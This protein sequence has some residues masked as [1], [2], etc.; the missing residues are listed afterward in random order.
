MTSIP[1]EQMVSDN[2]A[3]NYDTK[4]GWRE[5]KFRGRGEVAQKIDTDKVKKKKKERDKDNQEVKRNK[6][7]SEDRYRQNETTE[8]RGR[9]G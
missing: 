8:K 6:G 2:K 3:G 5:A 9:Y 4:E 7:C 1:I